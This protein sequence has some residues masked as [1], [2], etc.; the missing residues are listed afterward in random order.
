MPMGRRFIR[1]TGEYLLL[2]YARS[3]NVPG[4]AYL[5]YRWAHSYM[6]PW[7]SGAVACVTS[8]ICG[9]LSRSPFR[10]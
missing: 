1:C 5:R 10:I 7:A 6:E 3:W 2:K 9:T 4:I 8:A